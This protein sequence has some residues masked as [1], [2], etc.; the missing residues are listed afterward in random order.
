MNIKVQ[1]MPDTDEF[2]FSVG[3][4]T[5]VALVPSKKTGAE[6]FRDLAAVP[7]FGHVPEQGSHY[8]EKRPKAA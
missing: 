6:I 4:G 1:E 3:Y 8:P 7:K 2:D 5:A